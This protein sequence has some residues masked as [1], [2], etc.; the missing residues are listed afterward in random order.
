MFCAVL[1]TLHRENGT[2]LNHLADAGDEV[3]LAS[4]VGRTEAQFIKATKIEEGLF[5]STNTST[6][7]KINL[8]LKFFEQYHEDPANLVLLTDDSPSENSDLAERH[9]IRRKYWQNAI[10]AIQQS[11]GSF[12]NSGNHISWVFPLSSRPRVKNSTLVLTPWA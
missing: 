6:Q 4:N 11:T 3:E 10:S 2:I 7:S 9:L 8:L 1:T 12:L 5:V